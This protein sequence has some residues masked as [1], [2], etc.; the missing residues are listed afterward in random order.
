MLTQLLLGMVVEL[1]EKEPPLEVLHAWYLMAM[2]CTYTHTVVPAQRYLQRCQELIKAEDIRLVEPNW[3]DASTRASPSVMAIDDRPPEYTEKKHELV[4]VLVNLMYLQCMHRLMYGACHDLYAELEAQLP[5]FAVSFQQSRSSGPI[6][7]V[8]FLESLSGGFRSLLH[9]TQ[10][11]HG[12]FGPGCVPAHRTAQEAG[13]V[14][15]R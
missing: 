4:S 15:S 2:S 8:S 1:R 12:S 5:D 3:I 11:S 6:T 14:V 7:Q 10:N 13:L 9:D